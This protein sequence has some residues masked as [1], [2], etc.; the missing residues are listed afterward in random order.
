MDSDDR[1]L[2]EEMLRREVLSGSEQAWRVLYGETFDNLYNY[3]LWRCGGRRDWADEIV[4]ETW[5]TAAR[6]MRKFSP[7]QGTFLAW[8][9][10]IAANVLR[11][12]LRRQKKFYQTQRP[13]EATVDKSSLVELNQ[14]DCQ[15]QEQIAVVLSALPDRHEAVL[16]AKYL[17]GLSVAEIAVSWNATPKTIESLLSRARAAFRDSYQNM[18]GKIV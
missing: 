7:R 6:R 14:S 3:V 8:L 5:L 17:E 9:R 1:V 15:Q 16:R 12:H 10:G 13:A 11:N 2:R 18:F 4:Q